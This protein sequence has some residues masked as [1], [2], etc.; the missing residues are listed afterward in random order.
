MPLDKME[1]IKQ[2]QA[3]AQENPS[4]FTV[5]LPS[6]QFIT[7]GWVV[8]KKETQNSFGLEGLNKALEVALKTSKT[9][10]GWQDEELFYWDAVMVFNNEDEATQASIENEQLAIYNIETNY[11]KWL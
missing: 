7:R 9:I 6:L 3:I 1:L 8:A 2:L 11:L 5:S 10:G 4:G